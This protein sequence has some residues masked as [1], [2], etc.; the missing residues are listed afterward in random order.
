MNFAGWGDEG[1]STA[2]TPDGENED[3]WT[4]PVTYHRPASAKWTEE[5]W[6]FEKRVRVSYQSPRSMIRLIFHRE[7]I[8]PVTWCFSTAGRRDTHEVLLWRKIC[9]VRSAQMPLPNSQR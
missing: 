6:F 8:H 2:L 7:T 3:S 4:D 5:T 9:Q 1:K